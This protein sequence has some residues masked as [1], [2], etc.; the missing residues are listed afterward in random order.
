MSRHPFSPAATLLLTAAAMGCAHVPT[1]LDVVPVP[2]TASRP[3][4][5]LDSPPAEPAGTPMALPENWQELAR[6]L[7]LADVVDIALANNDDTRTAWLRARSAAARVGQERAD[8]FPSVDLSATASKSKRSAI[9]GQF[10]F[11]E[12]TW[13]PGVDLTWLLYDFGGRSARIDEARATLLAADWQHDAVIQSVVLEVERAYFSYL[14]ARA[15]LAA[16]KVTVD[17]AQTNLDAADKR[18]EVGVAT[19][20]D[21]LQARTLLSQARLRQ[22]TIEGQIDSLRGALATAMGIPATTDLEVGELPAELPATD[23]TTKV[24]DLIDRALAGRPDLAAA[25]WQAEQAARHVDR[26][27]AEG[28]PSLRLGGSADRTYYWAPQEISGA[29]ANNWS[30][31]LALTFPLFTGFDH[32]FKVREAEA[33]A[34]AAKADAH[35]FSQRVVLDVW[36]AFA[37]LKTAQQRIATAHD[38]LASAEESNRVARA[39]YQQGV[40]S[41]LDLLSTQATLANARSEEIQ[42]RSDWLVAVA[43]L[44]YATGSLT[45][46]TPTPAEASAQLSGTTTESTQP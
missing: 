7:T 32:S 46:K 36:T 10:K 3:A 26:V 6:E 13:G 12:G 25:R 5:N 37:D 2:E 40:G 33:D 1:R 17:E 28:R 44:A 27:K 22:Q 41:I 31:S 9:G 42:A 24:E 34:A 21:V 30:A 8:Y 29:S 20:A 39:R 43:N 4:A 38:L 18:R 35:R 15:E 11:T 45:P 23:V 14:A 16:A 19:V